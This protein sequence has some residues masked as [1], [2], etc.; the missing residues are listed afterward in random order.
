M[1]NNNKPT[2]SKV[3]EWKYDDLLRLNSMSE[4]FIKNHDFYGNKLLIKYLN[5][6]IDN[7]DTLKKID[8][9]IKHCAYYLLSEYHPIHYIYLDKYDINAKIYDYLIYNMDIDSVTDIREIIIEWDCFSIAGSKKSEYIAYLYTNVPNID[10]KPWHTPRWLSL[11]TSIEHYE[12]LKDIFGEIT[13]WNLD[14]I[15]SDENVNQDFIKMI[16]NDGLYKKEDIN[17]NTLVS[18]CRQHCKSSERYKILKY[19][20]EDLDIKLEPVNKFSRNIL[21]I[22]IFHNNLTLDILKLLTIHLPKVPDNLL[23]N[24]S[25]NYNFINKSEIIIWVLNHAQDL[26]I[27]INKIDW[28]RMMTPLDICLCNKYIENPDINNLLIKNGAKCFDEILLKKI[29]QFIIIA[30]L[31]LIIYLIINL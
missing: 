26:K 22:L 18:F 21:D 11:D 24:V 1:N 13:K 25:T 5:E 3:F 10:I 20:I 2:G 9:I 15:L 19:F 16:I 7:E 6:F 4:D 28:S 29:I 23:I 8:N 31:S 12:I 30:G 17:Y 14:I 27:N